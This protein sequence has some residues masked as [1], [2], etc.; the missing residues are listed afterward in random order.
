MIESGRVTGPTYSFVSV[1]R[2]TDNSPLNPVHKSA[3][4]LNLVLPA[5]LSDDDILLLLQYAS[6]DERNDHDDGDDD[7]EYG[8]GMSGG[9]T[10]SHASLLH[11]FRFRYRTESVM[12]PMASTNQIAPSCNK[13]NIKT[14]IKTLRSNIRRRNVENSSISQP[15]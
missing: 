5:P 8:E 4:A 9:N 6:A 3:Q 1:L 11:S 12:R 14:N 15:P 10:I 2:S 13:T 7:D